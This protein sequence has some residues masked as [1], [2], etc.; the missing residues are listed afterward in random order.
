MP[1]IDSPCIKICTL[2]PGRGL[3][4]GCGRTIEEIA[5]WSVMSAAERTTLMAQLPAR[6]CGQPAAKAEAE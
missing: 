2:D 1:L 4:L 6:L 5:A 3:C